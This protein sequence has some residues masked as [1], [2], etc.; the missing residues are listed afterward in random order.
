MPAPRCLTRTRRPHPPSQGAGLLCGLLPSRFL[1]K[2][3]EYNLR[4]CLLDAM[5]DKRFQLRRSFLKNPASLSRRFR[6]FGLLN[7]LLMPFIALFLTTYFVFK[8]V[9]D[10]HSKRTELSLREWSPLARWK[11]RELNELPHFFERRMNASYGPANVY[12]KQF[13]YPG[14]SIVARCACGPLLLAPCRSCA[15]ASRAPRGPSCA[16]AISF[17]TGALLGLLVIMSLVDDSLPLQIQVRPCNQPVQL[18]RASHCCAWPT[19]PRAPVLG[20]QPDLVHDRAGRHRG[21]RA[22]AGAAARGQ[23]D[24]PGGHDGEGAAVARAPARPPARMHART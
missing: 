20:P 19:A 3:L 21:H 17:A 5:F 8:H 4:W 12:E 22:R 15:A 1:T 14:L 2:H 24:G 10:F 7:L 23:G 9:E 13:P 6:L 11:F 16:S 18:R